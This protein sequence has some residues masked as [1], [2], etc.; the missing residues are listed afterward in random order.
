MANGTI[1]GQTVDGKIIVLVTT[2]GP[3]SYDATNGFSISV[4]NVN[5]IDSVL[6]VHI[7]GG[8]KI[9]DFSI[10]GN[11]VTVRVHYYSYA[12]TAAGP[13]TQVPAATDLSGTTITLVAIGF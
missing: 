6:F 9:G 12:A 4:D 11:T 7:D 5:R 2:S 1:I 3:A 10:S 8:Y 13:S